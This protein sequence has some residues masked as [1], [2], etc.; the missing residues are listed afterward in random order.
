MP[1]PLFD[2]IAKNAYLSTQELDW[3][4]LVA[5]C[6]KINLPKLETVCVHCQGQP[7]KSDQVWCAELR[8]GC[9]LPPS[10]SAWV[11]ADPSL[12][13]YQWS[14]LELLDFVGI[15]PMQMYAIEGLRSNEDFQKVLGGWL[16]RLNKIRDRLTCRT[17]GAIMYP[18]H[19]Y[20]KFLAAYP[21][22]IFKCKQHPLPEVKITHCWLCED[23]IDSRDSRFQDAGTNFNLCI[24]CGAGEQKRKS[25]G[26]ICPK[27]G[28]GPMRLRQHRSAKE[29]SLSDLF[30]IHS[31]DWENRA[32][33]C[34][35]GHL[36]EPVK[37]VSRRAGA[38]G[39]SPCLHPR[40]QPA[41]RP[42]SRHQAVHG[43]ATIQQLC[44]EVAPRRI[45]RPG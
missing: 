3:T 7:W 34:P 45:R 43:A 29:I 11:S 8:R 38:A 14:L 25:I 30:Q 36:T 17:C 33:S 2:T 41:S 20:A 12:P 37:P 4:P 44:R 13:P 27:C 23:V 19:G 22:T 32:V 40:P 28:Q 18:D 1:E 24:R 9:A 16:N 31:G 15:T 42:A 35:R 6:R 10:G 5:P 26:R 39:E 21:V